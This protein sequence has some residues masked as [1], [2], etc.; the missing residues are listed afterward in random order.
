MPTLETF[1]GGEKVNARLYKIARDICPDTELFDL[2]PLENK[3]PEWLKR[4]FEI[5]YL[6]RAFKMVY[7]LSICPKPYKAI[8]F[9]DYYSIKDLFIYLLILRVFFRSIN[10][11]YFHQISSDSNE[12]K[13]HEKI[14]TLRYTISF[15]VLNVILVNSMFNKK[16]I[17][18]L[19]VPE[20]KIKVLYPL[21]IDR[22]LQKLKDNKKDDDIIHLLFVGG[23]F[24]R[25][26][27]LYAIQ[28]IKLL[29]R[30]I[31]RFNIV[32]NINKEKRYAD[33]LTKTVEENGLSGQIKF[34]D[35]VDDDTLDLLWRTAD[36]F[37]FPTLYEG[38]GI[39]FAEAMSYQLPIISTNVSAVP[40][41]V[42]DGE[43]G[44]LVPP[45]N[46]DALVAAIAKLSE[47]TSLRKKMGENGHQKIKKF[48]ESYSIDIEFQNI[49]E[50]LIRK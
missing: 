30:K 38:F 42:Q 4:M 16:V 26:G 45:E 49:I 9:S 13:L 46:P 33:Y 43:N 44:I 19:G 15:L 37:L 1:T 3:T 35:K 48:Y 25:K 20:K 23:S 21:L 5:R 31:L 14:T 8:C 40:E 10:I 47:D 39:V 12:L 11:C 18:S 29:N 41:L 24:K 27:L 36:I 17:M 28:A 22:P 6:G 50:E 2:N 7:I 32:G 34:W